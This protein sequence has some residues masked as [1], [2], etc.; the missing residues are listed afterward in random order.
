MRFFCEWCHQRVD[1]RRTDFPSPEIV[2]HFM[3][4]SR[5]SEFM[6]EKKIAGLADHIATLVAEPIELVLR[7]RR[8]L[9]GR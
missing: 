3:R 7:M 1:I 5:R 6:D 9:R 8:A 4:C 2:N